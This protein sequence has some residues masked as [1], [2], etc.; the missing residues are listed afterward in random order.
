MTP[1]VKEEGPKRH[2]QTIPSLKR[3]CVFTVTWSNNSLF[4]SRPL[5]YVLSLLDPEVFTYDSIDLFG[6]NVYEDDHDF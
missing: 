6:E 4:T 5:I 1:D 2:I 3:D